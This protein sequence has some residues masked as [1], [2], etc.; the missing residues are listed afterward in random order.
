MF[1][2]A[3]KIFWLVAEPLSSL[4]VLACLG[5]CLGFTR[6]ARIGRALTAGAVVL[7]AIGVLTPFGPALLRP[8]EDRFAPPAPDSPPPTGI[9]VLGGGVS[10]A[11][12]QARK[13]VAIVGA[14]T[15]FTTAVELARRYPDARL[16][17]S[18]GSPALLEG[19]TEA[20]A[21]RE[22]WRALG[23][24]EGQMSFEAKSR[25][26]WENA[27]FTR[28]LVKPKP[29]EI[30]LLVTSAWHMPR[31]VGI[32]RRL[33]FNVTAYPVDYYT[34]GDGRDWLMNVSALDRAFMFEFG[35]R[36][37]IGLVVY[38]MTGKTDAFF[39]AP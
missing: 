23:V 32:F 9:I 28:D 26:T 31:A 25:N 21:V 37:W 14:A 16:V 18:G 12:T 35:V 33:G 8:L 24:P 3:S 27:L 2:P 4:I 11:L 20:F 36:E 39:P 34:F 1:F 7:L 29:G 38:R 19:Q 22:L 6:F 10:P 15:R 17:F 13:Q 5:L 30:W